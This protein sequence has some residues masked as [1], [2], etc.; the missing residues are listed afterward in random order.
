MEKFKIPFVD[1]DDLFKTKLA[2]GRYKDLAD[3]EQLKK[4]KKED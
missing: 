3:I 2:T 1:I 4:L